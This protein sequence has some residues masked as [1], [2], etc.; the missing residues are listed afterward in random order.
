MDVQLEI[1]NHL[2]WKGDGMLVGIFEDEPMP[3]A[4][5][6]IDRA[7]GGLLTTLRDTGEVQSTHG[8][9]TLVHT[10]HELPSDR[11]C[12]VGLGSRHKL[13]PD[14]LRH[15]TAEGAKVL[16]RANARRIASILHKT[17]AEVLGASR[18]AQAVVEG[19]Q[20]GLWRFRKYHTIPDTVGAI[21]TLA[22]LELDDESRQQAEP[23]VFLG[24]ICGRA[25]NLARDLVNE[26]GNMLTPT[27]LTEIA[28]ALAASQGLDFELV[29][30]ND[31]AR[32]GMGAFLG[33]ARGSDEPPAL[34]ILRYWG[35]GHRAEPGLGLVGKG[36]TFDSGGISIKPAEKMEEQKGDMAGGA[37]VIAALWAIAQ[38]KPEI[39]VTGLVA[40]TENMPSGKAVKPGDVLRAMNGKT[41]EVVNTDAEGRLV[42]ADALAYATGTLGLVPV[43][44]AATL[45]GAVIEALWQHRAGL[46]SNDA[47]LG[48]LVHA[49]GEETGER[50]WELP[51]DEEY[52][53]LIESR[54]ADIK[55]VGEHGGGAIAAAW[56]LRNFVGQTSWA[57]LDIAG[58]HK[59]LDF[60][61]YG[62]LNKF[63]NGMPT[64]T[65][66]QL[67]LALA[68]TKKPV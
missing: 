11:V 35:A 27:R 43:V 55:N 1:A 21:E 48:A 15:A 12:I 2:H 47:Q 3:G 26:P 14:R 9:V 68:E 13:S 31:A 29:T 10:S 28:S 38:L 49:I 37:A 16:R 66:I 59:L 8:A 19:A 51:M 52:T 18:A 30:Q 61:E 24:G 33:V 32:L 42:L 39:N 36:I 60:E 63:G 40:A 45:T 53:R 22:L 64:R 58:S 20:M 7:L 34:I 41:I 5:N 56:F 46:F 67:A 44:D 4:V 62:Y 54:W 23:G 17:G 57:H 65:F 6:A 50:N 25:T